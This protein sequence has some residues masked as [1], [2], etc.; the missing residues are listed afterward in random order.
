[1]QKHIYKLPF[2]NKLCECDLCQIVYKSDF[3]KG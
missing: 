3:K 1:M 2:P